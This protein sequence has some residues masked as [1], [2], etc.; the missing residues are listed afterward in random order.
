MGD[1][2]LKTKFD[3]FAFDAAYDRM[4]AESVFEMTPA[5]RQLPQSNEASYPKYYIRDCYDEYYGYLIQ[6]LDKGK[7]ITTVTGTPGIGKSVFYA[8]FFQEYRESNP[9]KQIVT[10]SF[11]ESRYLLQVVVYPPFVGERDGVLDIAHARSANGQLKKRHEVDLMNDYPDAIHL[12]D[13]PPFASPRR[14]QMICFT[15]PNYSWLKSSSKSSPAI[16]YMPFW[17]LDELIEAHDFLNLE[18][19]HDEVERRYSLVGGT[20]RVCLTLDPDEVVDYV[21]SLVTECR[22]IK[23]YSQLKDFVVFNANTEEV[24]HQMLFMK[25]VF[26]A[27]TTLRTYKLYFC[28]AY[29][30]DEVYKSI[31]NL[32]EWDKFMFISLLKAD[33]RASSLLEQVF[34]SEMKQQ[35]IAGGQFNLLP[36]GGSQA[37][38]GSVPLDIDANRYKRVDSQDDSAFQQLKPAPDQ[39]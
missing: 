28:S 26:G 27:Y 13:G 32:S 33:P 15:C 8:H 7:F 30:A 23:S 9:D 17:S 21:Q 3:A 10:A 38:H 25:P 12:Y 16:F 29:I 14:T 39:R 31:I 1:Q 24:A 5:Q 2:S 19:G 18:I 20:A 6:S 11:D 35:L 34:K 36:L 4:V 37:A 22:L